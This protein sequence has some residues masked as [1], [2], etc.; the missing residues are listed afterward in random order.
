LSAALDLLRARLSNGFVLAPNGRMLHANDPDRSA[1]PLFAAGT[2]AD[3]TI[4]LFRDD[5]D[6]ATANAIIDDLDDLAAQADAIRA[7]L[8]LSAPVGRHNFERIHRLPRA[9]RF[10]GP[11]V[12]AQGTP[13]GDVLWAQL[14]RDGLPPGIVAQGFT[15]LSHLWA[16][17][18]VVM[19][20]DEIASIAFAARLSDE[21]AEIGVATIPACRG[22][23]Y[24]AAVTA[25]WSALP[26]LADR[27]LFY[28]T[29]LDNR[30]SLRVIERLALPFLGIGFTL[31]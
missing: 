6:D 11:S 2:R 1:A 26:L 31:P 10:D 21:A 9:T 15:D 18:C 4:A 27:E 17:W 28:S 16:P 22:R 12:I 7:R 5:V 29:H 3:G 13:Q 20:D 30:S 14:E 23:G 8:G 24:A 19:D 25:A